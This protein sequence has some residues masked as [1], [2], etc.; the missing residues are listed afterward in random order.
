MVARV[1]S[2]T[3]DGLAALPVAVE[4]DVAGG[5]PG[6]TMVGL[7]DTAVRESKERV[8]SALRNSGYD[9]PPRRI[10]VSLAPGDLRKAG[11]CFDLPV[12]LGILAAMAAFPPEAIEGL[13]VMGELSLDGRVDG[14]DP[15]F[16]AALLAIRMKVGAM[17]L[18]ERMAREAALVEGCRV[19]AARRLS[20]AIEHLRGA[21]PLEPFAPP[22]PLAAAP[23]VDADLC[24]VR[25]QDLARRALEVAAAGGHNL[26][27]SGP[28]GSGKTMLA[29]RLP[30]ILPPLRAEESLEV[31]AIHSVA[32][33]L[34]REASLLTVP[35]FRAP[36]HTISDIGLAGGGAH[37]RPGEVTLAHRGVLFLDEM[38]EFSRSAL[39][40]LRQP[41]E[42]G[43]IVVTRAARSLAFP[44][45]FQ[46]VG[47]TNPC[48]CGFAGH[49][50]RPCCCSPAALARYRQRISGPLLDRI[51]LLVEVPAL[52]P[53]RFA[54]GPPGENS[55][56]VR[57]RVME[58]RGRQAAR[59][60]RE[61]LVPL[62][63]RLTPSQLE[64]SCPLDAEGRRLL[65]E[66]GR[67]LALTAR[68]LHRALRVA[69]TLADLDG[70]ERPR[71]EHLAEA[72]QYR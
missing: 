57:A 32:G 50:L 53:E 7:A 3:L 72:L 64:R 40:S 22:L 34:P 5:L 37:P 6:L 15:C 31:T 30:G 2:C 23:P 59:A 68:G 65:A 4:I 20:E 69:R 11:S 60:A 26:L 17:L 19:L 16:P 13:L 35:P 54:G 47:A 28:P 39:E 66:A 46:L 18:P 56:A 21:F 67:R 52:P 71:P 38:A 25:G 45:R 29:R 10:T 51:D 1:L 27:F 44:S 62:N 33:L 49:A 24:E 36:H 41:L 70:A 63:A 42:D 61:G 14:N 58:A 43:R 12:A 8:I 48:P 55:E 9:L